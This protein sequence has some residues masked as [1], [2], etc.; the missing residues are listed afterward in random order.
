MWGNL[1]HTIFSQIELKFT[2]LAKVFLF[3][4]DKCLIFATFN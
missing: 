4:S 2:D 3:H 1:Y